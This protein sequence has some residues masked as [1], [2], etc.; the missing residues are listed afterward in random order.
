MVEDLDEKR[1]SETEEDNGSN[2]AVV[3]TLENIEGTHEVYDDEKMKK[4]GSLCMKHLKDKKEVSRRELKMSI[5]LKFLE[6]PSE[7]TLRE[8]LEEEDDLTERDLWEMG[9]HVLEHMHEKTESVEI[10]KDS[11]DHKYRWRE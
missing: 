4:V 11:E 6:D 2:R 3:D 9:K 8:M 1:G 5:Y 10:S 7:N